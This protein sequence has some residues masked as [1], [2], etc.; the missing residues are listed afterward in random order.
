MTDENGVPQIGCSYEENVTG[1][2]RAAI[3]VQG[4]VVLRR[5]STTSVLN[6]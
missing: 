3:T 4:N 6:Q 2:I 1:L 5:V